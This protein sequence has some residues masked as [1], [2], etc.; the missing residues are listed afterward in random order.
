MLPKPWTEIESR[1]KQ[2]E[3]L[4]LTG[5]ARG[6]H[7]VLLAAPTMRELDA[8]IRSTALL[9]KMR[10]TAIDL[11]LA[12]DAVELRPYDE[13]DLY[14]AV[15]AIRNTGTRESPSFGVHFV[16][17]RGEDAKTKTMT[18]GAGPIW[19]NDHWNEMS[20]PF[21][22]EEG[23]ND[24]AVIVDPDDAISETDE[25]NN[26]ASLRVVVKGGLIVESGQQR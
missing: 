11:V 10:H 13:G 9:D 18:H 4:E 22:L 5:E 7:V 1:V 6:L 8:L 24:I 17:T 21:A 23:V 12:S 14:S 15:V 26:R 20:M 3:S 2:G 25:T 16:L 19:P